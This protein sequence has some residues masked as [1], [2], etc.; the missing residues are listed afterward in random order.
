[1]YDKNIDRDDLEKALGALQSLA[2]A[3]GSTATTRVE[4][5]VGESG[6]TQLFHTASN[7][8]PGSWAGSTWRGDT[9]EDM[10]EEDGTNLGALKK[11]AES[12]MDK[13]SKGTSLNASEVEFVS[14]GGLNFLNKKEDDKDDKKE[15][16]KVSKAGH[17]DE[18]EDK[19]LLKE[20]VKPGA[21]KSDVNKSFMDHAAENPAVQP[22]FE[23]SEFLAGFA[24]VMHK[25]LQSMEARITD[26][27]LTAIASNAE[28]QGTV[29]KS[30]A[31][32]VASLG[33]VLTLHAQ[34]LEQVESAPARGPKTEMTVNKSIAGGGDVHGIES[35][36][37]SQI[38]ERLLDLVEKSQA[39]PSDV[40]KF[41]ATGTLSPELARKVLGR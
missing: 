8:D 7:S 17:P 15:D 32:A 40:L 16:D 37:K 1:M 19:Q 5:M 21:L 23:V 25:S 30:M 3:Q 12:V 18:K 41:D 28:E 10:I 13:I 29:Q 11:F 14:K 2:K 4:A 39:S 31:E 24:E 9:W 22:G 38:S 35:L 36:S 27:V 6:S 26:R 33:E 34:R 20:M